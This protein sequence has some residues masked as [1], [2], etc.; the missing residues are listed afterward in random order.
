VVREELVFRAALHRTAELF[1]VYT[2]SARLDGRS[3]RSAV[4]IRSR[5][6]PDR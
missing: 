2:V 4:N 6:M 5:T 3:V 1:P